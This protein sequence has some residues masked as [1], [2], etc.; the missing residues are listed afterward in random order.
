MKLFAGVTVF[1]LLLATA[2]AS[3]AAESAGQVAAIAGMSAARAA[4]SATRLADGRV[5]LAG[6]CHAR[7]CEEGISSD[8]VI[9]DPATKRFAAAGRLILA[10]AG[11][12]ALSLA[13]GR[14]F[15][16]GGWTPG[17]ATDVVEVYD[18]AVGSFAAHGKLLQARDGFSATLLNDGRILMVGGYARDMQRLSSAEVYDTATGRSRPVADMAM[19]RMSHTATRLDDGRV[20]V[21]GGSSARGQL[22]D[23]LEL[24]DP[25]SAA[26]AVVGHLHKARHKHAAVAVGDGVLIMGGAGLRESA[27]QYRESELWRPGMSHTTPGPT[28]RNARYKFLDAVV[29]L[30]DG[31]TLIAGGSRTVEALDRKGEHF[32]TVGGELGADLA[33]STATQLRDGRV[34]IA[35]GYD[36]DIQPVRS[37]WLYQTAE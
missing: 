12:R 1:A 33:F 36:P 34:L 25:V 29:R 2:P 32:T 16:F 30:D 37:A 28:M 11:H 4:H 19:P 13:D 20:L 15:L 22:V 6:G 5:L 26:F 21:A 10:R 24:F 8:A 7:G 27:Q 9:F 18:P 31:R 17:G 14:V 35:G 3:E 23:T